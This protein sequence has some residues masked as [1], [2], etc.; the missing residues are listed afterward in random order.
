MSGLA[1]L[2]KHD[3]A[4]KS[5]LD[6]PWRA[7]GETPED[8]TDPAYDL[9]HSGHRKRCA[10]EL[11]KAQRKMSRRRH[12]KGIKA[13]RRHNAARHQAATLHKKAARQVQHDARVVS[14]DLPGHHHHQSGPLFEFG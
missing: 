7:Q 8:E 6:V 1:R 4:P 12:G 3:A 14:R 11:A 2:L 10:A 9:P 13:S 5:V